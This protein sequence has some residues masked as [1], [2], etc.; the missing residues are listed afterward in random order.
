MK[1]HS[2]VHA[3]IT[4]QQCDAQRNYWKNLAKSGSCTAAPN[5]Y[6]PQPYPPT[7]PPTYP[8]QPTGGGWVGGVYYPDKSGTC[9]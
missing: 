8:P 3:G 4:Y 2:D 7:Y 6:P 1:I 5:P 9:G